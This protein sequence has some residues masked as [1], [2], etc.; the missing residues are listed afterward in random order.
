MTLGRA[1]VLIPF[2]LALLAM[3]AGAAPG[4]DVPRISAICDGAARYAS[5]RTGVPIGVLRAISLTE[6][7][8]TLSGGFRPWPWTVNMEG[9]GLWFDSRDEALAYA[10]SSHGKGKRSFD[11]GCFQLNYRWH[12]DGFASIEEMFDPAAN[13]MYAAGFLSDLFREFGDWTRAAGA[14]HSRTPVYANRY[15]ARF[16]RILS[17]LDDAPP[18][19]LLASADPEEMP[20][21]NAEPERPERANTYP[22]FT[23]LGRRAGPASLV[24]LDGGTSARGLFDRG[25]SR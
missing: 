12:G 25:E 1:A 2:V 22:L 21:A 7:G 5:E 13:A 6:T 16:A 17:T 18:E 20:M 8:R 14:Y 4:A 11:V 15:S 23:G 24:L 9:K 10:L 19:V 3:P